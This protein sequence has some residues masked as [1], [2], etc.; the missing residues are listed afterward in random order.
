[1]INII[2]TFYVSKYKSELD[3]LRSKELEDSLVNNISSPFVE[4]LHLFLDDEDALNRVKELSK[5]SEKVVI[6][7][8]GKKPKYNDFFKYILDNLKNKICMITNSDIYLFECDNRLIE[9]A[10]INMIAYALTRYEYDFSILLFVLFLLVG[11][12]IIFKLLLFLNI[13][14]ITL[15]FPK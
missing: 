7:E 1:M 2:S 3:Y 13:S 10:N 5:N 4:K 15:I 8:V 12:L 6:I 9:S 11:I 14:S